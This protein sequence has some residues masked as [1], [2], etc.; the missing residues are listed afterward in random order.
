MKKPILWIILALLALVPLFMMKVGDRYGRGGK[1]SSRPSQK[2]SVADVSTAPRQ[3]SKS[4]PKEVESER[5]ARMMSDKG[6]RA[7]FKLSEQDI[8]LY[9]QA[10][11]S[12]AVS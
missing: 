4:R 12:N 3:Y 10:N 6:D 5:R 8:Y 7:D 11:N 1:G 9:L 2:S